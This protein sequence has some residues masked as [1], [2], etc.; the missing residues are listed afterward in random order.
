MVLRHG[1]NVAIFK[2]S[3]TN[4]DEIVTAMTLGRGKNNGNGV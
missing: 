1:A 3:Q 4:P 2:T